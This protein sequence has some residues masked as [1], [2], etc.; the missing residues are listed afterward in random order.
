[1]TR[2]KLSKIRRAIEEL[3]GASAKAIDIQ[4]LAKQLGRVKIKRGKEPTWVSADFGDMLRPLSIP[5]HGGR[6]FPPGTKNSMLNS[7][8]DDVFA[9]DERLTQ[10]ERES[11]G[12]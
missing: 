2:N 11:R 4:R 3:R 12:R 10:E 6:D 8:E 5:D 1:M 9:W 7:L